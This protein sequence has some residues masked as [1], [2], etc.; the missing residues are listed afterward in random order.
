MLRERQREGRMQVSN[1]NRPRHGPERR[2]LRRQCPRAYPG[3]RPGSRA[4][5]LPSSPASSA[6]SDGGLT[7]PQPLR[8][9]QGGV[10][11]RGNSY[12]NPTELLQRTEF[13]AYQIRDSNLV[14][15]AKLMQRRGVYA[16]RVHCTMKIQQL[17][18]C[19]IY[20]ISKNT[21]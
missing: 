21:K 4:A 3:P 6:S 15:R 19:R 17:R 18:S 8:R 10:L 11:T 7:I 16:S 2:Q 1:A 13:C 9:G 5:C 12:I 14:L 20:S